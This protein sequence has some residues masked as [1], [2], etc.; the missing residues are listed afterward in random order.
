MRITHSR[1]SRASRGG[2]HYGTEHK[3]VTDSDEVITR[4]SHSGGN[5][6]TLGALPP[7][8]LPTELWNRIQTNNEQRS[9]AIPVTSHS[10]PLGQQWR[11]V[12]REGDWGSDP[13][14]ALQQVIRHNCDVWYRHRARVEEAAWVR[15]ILTQN[16]RTTRRRIGRLFGRLVAH[17]RSNL[18][19]SGGESWFRELLGLLAESSR[20]H[21]RTNPYEHVISCIIGIT[22]N[23]AGHLGV[24]RA[25]GSCTRIRSV[26]CGS[27]AS[28]VVDPSHR[29]YG[30]CQTCLDVGDTPNICSR[31]TRI[32]YGDPT[33]IEDTGD[34][35]GSGCLSGLFR[36]PVTRRY[37]S[38]QAASR[39]SPMGIIAYGQ[40]RCHRLDGA[41]IDGMPDC[42]FELEFLPPQ[43][44]ES[45]YV[46]TVARD[47]QTDEK[48]RRW[49]AG[50]ERDGS[51]ASGDGAEVVTHYGP[52]PLLLEAAT[53]ICTV[54]RKHHCLSHKTP[55]H[56][57]C[58]LHV[59]IGRSDATAEHIARYVA[60][61]NDL[62]NRDFLRTFARRW[63]TGY[64]KP[65]PGKAIAAKQALESGDNE[66]ID[67]CCLNGD[68]YELINLQNS[69]RI[70]VRA[71]RGSTRADTVRACI[72]LSV[73]L[74][75]YCSRT[76]VVEHLTWERFLSWCKRA[77]VKC[78]TGDILTPDELVVYWQRR[79]Q[80]VQRLLADDAMIAKILGKIGAEYAVKLSPRPDWATTDVLHTVAARFAHIDKQNWS[81]GIAKR[82]KM[83]L[84]SHPSFYLLSDMSTLYNVCA[85]LRAPT[86]SN[87]NVWNDAMWA[88]LHV[89]SPVLPHRQRTRAENWLARLSSEGAT[90][91][92]LVQAML[93]RNED[94]A[95][96]SRSLRH[97]MSVIVQ[98]ES[99]GMPIAI[100]S[101]PW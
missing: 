7:S 97:V 80:W 8:R 84:V 91:V 35:V 74:W 44:P 3:I 62:H 77:R 59:A 96:L 67:D 21:L 76:T 52:L 20:R 51:I 78:D 43:P 101:V 100:P 18:S 63:D 70:E 79:G 28:S 16:R 85:N 98:R 82:T 27:S 34:L 83:A 68:R 81:V 10:S 13:H 55:H 12:L 17:H 40:S 92:Q 38:S 24:C 9:R 73:W 46:S 69:N 48:S 25:C 72:L 19:L 88:W 33:R 71:Y 56:S 4:W 95:W 66:N 45:G 30:I 31:C 1:P 15:P 65:A 6:A 22:T 75:R 90:E 2:E 47:L 49:I 57:Q 41:A 36:N 60:F 5:A 93:L 11:S 54:L 53:D 99:E 64:C 61:W 23:T 87:H 89:I 94:S 29:L 37:Y 14:V 86:T 39:G 26:C 42:G 58:G 32:I 50:I